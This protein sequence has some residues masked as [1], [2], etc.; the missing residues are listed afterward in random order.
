MFEEKRKSSP[1][2][3]MEEES[4]MRDVFLS[5]VRHVLGKFPN[6]GRARYVGPRYVGPLQV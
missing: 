1:A 4:L 6:S 2:M 5:E 3:T